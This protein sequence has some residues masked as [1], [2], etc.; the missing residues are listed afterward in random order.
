MKRTVLIFRRL[1]Q[2]FIPTADTLHWIKKWADLVTVS[3]KKHRRKIREKAKKT[4]N[5]HLDCTLFEIMRNSPN[6]F[7]P[8]SLH[9]KSNTPSALQTLLK[10]IEKVLEIFF[11]KYSGE[12]WGIV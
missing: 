4:K 2:L 8:A 7:K 11:L 12:L 6:R 5:A 9:F 10:A 1:I 3:A